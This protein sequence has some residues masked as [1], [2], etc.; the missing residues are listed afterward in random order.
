MKRVFLLILICLFC[1]SAGYAQ[2]VQESPLPGGAE[3]GV[4]LTTDKKVY[5]NDQ[6]I[7]VTIYN[8][9]GEGIIYRSSCSLDVCR[10]YLNDQDWRC[11]RKDCY[12]SKISLESGEAVNIK[13]YVSRRGANSFKCRFKYQGRGDKIERTVYSDEFTVK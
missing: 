6:V 11:E 9:T 10:Y 8:K 12:G 13:P 2:A 1:S 7:V 4:I 5:D 3:S